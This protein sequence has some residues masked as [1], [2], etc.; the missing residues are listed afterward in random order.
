M[1]LNPL[2]PVPAQF[3]DLGRVSLNCTDLHHKQEQ[4]RH[5]L[6]IHFFF[7]CSKLQAILIKSISTT[8]KPSFFNL[9]ANSFI[10]SLSPVSHI[11]AQLLQE[12][13]PILSSFF[14]LGFYY[15]ERL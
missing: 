11:L 6:L 12:T 10:A 4:L 9:S 5:L 3:S 13:I 14:Q 8:L 7:N 15:P 1:H 2:C